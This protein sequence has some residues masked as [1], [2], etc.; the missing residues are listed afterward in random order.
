MTAF[1]IHVIHQ[2]F[3]SLQTMRILGIFLLSSSNFITVWTQ[4]VDSFKDTNTLE[5][6]GVFFMIYK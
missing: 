5:F 3:L 6:I 2:Y 4:N 1:Q